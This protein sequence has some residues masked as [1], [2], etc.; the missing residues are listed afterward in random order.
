MADWNPELYSRFEDERTR[1]ARDLLARVPLDQSGFVVDLGCG[2]GNST[3][4]LADRYPGATVLGIDSSPA[5][6]DAAR[7]RLPG[8]RFEEADLSVWRPTSAPDLIFANAVLQWLPDHANLI[9]R[10][11]G[12]LAPRGVLA[13]QMPDNLAEPSPRLMREVAAE[14]PWAERLAI[15]AAARG[16]LPPLG[17]YYDMVADQA[18]F[19]DVWRTAYQH[20]MRTP[21]E[22]VDWLRATGLRPFLDSL[23]SDEQ[24]AFLDRYERQI[25][26]AYPPRI[27]GMRLLGFPRMFLVAQR[28]GAA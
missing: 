13:V 15:A 14:A 5:M 27:D 24:K 26:A 4:L 2:P 28:T 7:R 11:F 20:P 18:T 25:D 17:A 10:L 21:G 1:P 22:I 19:V 12:L 9:P 3:E 16:A 6:V 23:G 8:L